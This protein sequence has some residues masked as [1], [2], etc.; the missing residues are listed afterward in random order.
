[1]TLHP[2]VRLANLGGIRG[3]SENL[4]NECVRVQ[5]DRRNELLELLR[6]MLRGRGR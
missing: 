2:A 1:M 5:S 6:G 3:S 4:H